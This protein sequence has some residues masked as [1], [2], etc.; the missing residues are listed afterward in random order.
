MTLGAPLQTSRIEIY[1]QHGLCDGSDATVAR[2]KPAILE[3]RLSNSQWDKFCDDL[4]EALKPATKMRKIMLGGI[5]ALPITF[6]VLAG[7]SFITFTH[8]PHNFGVSALFFVIIGFT[9]FAGIGTLMCVATKSENSIST[10][11]CSVSLSSKLV[12]FEY[13]CC[14]DSEHS[15]EILSAS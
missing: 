5:I 3:D 8:M 7:I 13:W 1:G 15:S 9:M 4:D 12:L 6:V 11:I 14:D 2:A 10:A